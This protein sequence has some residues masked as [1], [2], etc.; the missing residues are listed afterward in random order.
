MLKRH[1]ILLA[2]I[3]ILALL[4]LFASRGLSAADAE[5]GRRLYEAHC[6]ECHD[7]SVHARSRRQALDYEAI[8]AWV[9]RWN[10]NL[11]LKWG[12]EEVGDVARHLNSTYYRFACPPQNCPERS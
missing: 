11:G 2:T 6:N 1:W 12:A 7:R 10:S 5:R 8:V 9:E 3:A 4:A